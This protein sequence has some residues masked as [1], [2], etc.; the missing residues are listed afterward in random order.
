VNPAPVN[1][2]VNPPGGVYFEGRELE[3]TPVP[4]A[5]N[6]FDGWSGDL[7]GFSNPASLVMDAAKTIT[8]AF[9]ADTDSDGISDAEEDAGPNVGDG[10]VVGAGTVV[11]QNV[12]RCYR[13]ARTRPCHE[14][15]E[16][17]DLEGLIKMASLLARRETLPF[18]KAK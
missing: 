5:G 4:D 15:V 16:R 12:P 2:T 11:I 8:A 18:N 7:S 17:P 6:A 13:P 10:A 3:V 9:G 14:S 1:G